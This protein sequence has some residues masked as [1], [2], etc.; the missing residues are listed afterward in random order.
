MS[1]G[2]RKADP[3]RE[4]TIRNPFIVDEDINAKSSEL[5]ILAASES[6]ESIDVEMQVVFSKGYLNR[7]VY[8]VGKMIREQLEHG[9]DYAKM[10]KV[11]SISFVDGIV[12]S[13][14]P[15]LHAEFSFYERSSHHRLME[16]SPEI[17]FLQL[18]RLNLPEDADSARLEELSELEKLCCMIRYQGVT[19]YEPLIRKLV[20]QDRKGLIRMIAE[21][22]DKIQQD[23]R[24]YYQ[25]L[26][27]EKYQFIERYREQRE[28]E[29]NA[30]NAELKEK[31]AYL[32]AELEKYKKIFGSSSNGP[33]L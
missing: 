13:E 23:E 22:T 8:Y 27:R 2:R 1:I 4:V 24:A 33:L 5:D 25:A 7:T 9:D 17:H 28:A 26:A 6:G 30:E 10:K 11:I 3:I 14:L 21:K 20:E 16:E 15:T 29:L 19:G 12:F 32:E 31:N 18:H